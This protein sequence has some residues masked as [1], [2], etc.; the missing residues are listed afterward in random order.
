MS[1]PVLNRRQAD[2]F[3]SNKMEVS[4]DSH[5][6]ASARRPLTPSFRLARVVQIVIGFCFLVGCGWDVETYEFNHAL[7][8]N[9]VLHR[10][11]V[12]KVTLKG[13]ANADYLPDQTWVNPDEFELYVGRPLSKPVNAGDSLR[14]DLFDP[15]SYLGAPADSRQL[16]IRHFWKANNRLV[17]CSPDKERAVAVAPGGESFIFNPSTGHRVGPLPAPTTSSAC[18]AFHG[19]DYFDWTSDGQVFARLEYGQVSLLHFGGSERNIATPYLVATDAWICLAITPNGRFLVVGQTSG[20]VAVIEVESGQVHCW[21]NGPAGLFNLA[22]LPDNQTLVGVGGG[23]VIYWNLNERQQV[24]TH[25]LPCPTFDN[26]KKRPVSSVA[27]SRDGR[28]GATGS[29]ASDLVLWQLVTGEVLH[30]IKTPLK[31]NRGVVLSQDG[32]Y[33]AVWPG[34]DNGED[35]QD[36]HVFE[37][38][39]GLLY[40]SFYLRHLGRGSNE[41]WS[42]DFSADNLTLVTSDRDSVRVWKNTKRD[43][44]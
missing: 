26:G 29:G 42:V 39:S 19:D 27:M 18:S 4:A 35:S 30:V 28:H 21:L 6:F 24:A 10:D 16:P 2:Y 41:I 36:V 37:V 14:H 43:V 33:V 15:R 1:W 44:D 5:H 17:F 12:T 40:T 3:N 11:D 20:K 38:K 23:R 8:V 7:K 9:E 32:A 25:E 13:A 22:C 31:Q 34:G